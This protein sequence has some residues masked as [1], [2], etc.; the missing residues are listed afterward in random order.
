MKKEY[1][2]SKAKVRKKPTLNAKESKIQTSVRIDADIFLWLQE[3]AE[4]QHTP[5][6]ALMNKYLREAM[7]KPS[8]ENRLAALEKA[9]FKKTP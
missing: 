8:L 4:K 2:F 3:E 7:G 1:N 5:Y 6:Q 9:I